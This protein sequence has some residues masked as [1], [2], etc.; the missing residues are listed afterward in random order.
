M[1]ARPTVSIFAAEGDEEKVAKT[2]RLPGVFLAP[3][4][5]D[6]V[7][8]VHTGLAKNA[9]QPYCVNKY[10][11]KSVSASSWG[12]GRAVSRIP[13]VQGGGT[14]R[15]GQGAFGNMCRGGRMF[16]PTKQWRKWHQKVN[17]T[18]RRYAVCSA[19]AASAVPALVMARGHKIDELP[20]VPL[21]VSSGAEKTTKTAAAVA[22]LKKLG[23]YQD[24]EK[25]IASKTMRAGKG[26][27][28]N[29]R[30]VQ[31]RGPLVIFDKDD[32]ITRAFRNIPGVELA[33]VNSLNL[34][35]LAPGGHLGRFCV[36]TQPAFE[37]LDALFGT[38]KKPS[39]E[40]THHKAAYRLPQLQMT[41]SDLSRLINSDEVQSKVNAPKEGT[42]PAT[43]KRNPLK[44][45]A[46][47]EELNPAAGAAK[48]RAVEKQ[49]AAVEAK[50]KLVKARR[51]GKAPSRAIPKEQK[52]LKKSFHALMTAD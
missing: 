6:V 12:T 18:Q 40:K 52:E 43:L 13:R 27:M 42:K 45:A 34:L 8:Q 28:R 9:R 31:R 26:K 29:R 10:A 48:K 35:Q 4:R 20:E 51:E 19:L 1:A 44:V 7:H 46:V 47:M 14:H 39:S 16:A 38:H 32:G 49:K 17:V 33:N 2:M 37:R 21:V 36:W 50:A 15:S 5:P 24:V 11:G 25:V 3:V 41:N 22:L 23:A 30:F